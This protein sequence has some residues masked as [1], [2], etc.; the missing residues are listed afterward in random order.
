MPSARRIAHARRAIVYTVDNR[1][2]GALAPA[3][4]IRTY[5]PV[6]S[7]SKVTL[8]HRIGQQ[9]WTFGFL[10]A[11]ETTTAPFAEVP[12]QREARAG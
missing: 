6:D 10:M 1:A 2:V 4:G 7:M 9:S 12:F 8:P 11:H 5:N 3:W